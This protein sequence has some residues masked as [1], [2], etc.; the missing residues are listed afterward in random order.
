MSSQSFDTAAMFVGVIVLA[1]AGVASVAALK[2]VEK[3]MAP[4]RFENIDD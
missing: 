1:V 2:W 4:W 3:R